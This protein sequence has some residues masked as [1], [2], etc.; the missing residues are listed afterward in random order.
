VANKL[1]PPQSRSP[2]RSGQ[3]A[4][5]TTQKTQRAGASV[6]LAD[7]QT[8]V[9]REVGFVSWPALKRHVEELRSLEGE[10]RLATLEMTARRCLSH[11]THTRILFDGDRFRTESRRRTTTAFSPSTSTPRRAQ[12]RYRVRR[13]GRK[14]A[15]LRRHLRAEGRPDDALLGLAGASRPGRR[16]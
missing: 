14:P 5:R 15:N 13:M 11:V 1:P 7:A 3:D 9:A 12:D 8:V 6:R 10:W 4:A 2:S 16:S